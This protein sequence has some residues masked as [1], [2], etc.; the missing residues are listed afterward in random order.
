[1]QRAIDLNYA[2]NVDFGSATL[3]TNASASSGLD[4]DAT[5][6]LQIAIDRCSVAWTESGPPYT[7]TCGGT[8]SAVL[9]SRPLIGSNVALEPHP[10]RRHDR[11]PPGDGH[12]PEHRR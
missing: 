1:M 12:A 6:G 3:T 4:T 8:P 11:P 7:Y 2:G 10:H 9:A 5:D